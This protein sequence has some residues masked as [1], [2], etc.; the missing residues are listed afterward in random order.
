MLT[1]RRNS[2]NIQRQPPDLKHATSNGRLTSNFFATAGGVA[3]GSHHRGGF[4]KDCLSPNGGQPTASSNECSPVLGHKNG[5]A[6]AIHGGGLRPQTL[7]QPAKVSQSC[8]TIHAPPPGFDVED[9]DCL[10]PSSLQNYTPDD[11]CIESP[12]SSEQQQWP[13]RTVAGSDLHHH[14]HH[15]HDDVPPGPAP[16]RPSS[17][18][19]T[20]WMRCINP[21]HFHHHHHHHDPP[22]LPITLTHNP[23]EDTTTAALLFHPPQYQCVICQHNASLYRALSNPSLFTRPHQDSLHKATSLSAASAAKKRDSCEDNLHH[24]DHD[25]SGEC[26]EEDDDDDQDH[27]DD[28]LEE[29]EEEEEEEDCDGELTP[30][31]QL[32]LRRHRM[33][34]S[35]GSFKDISMAVHLAPHLRDISGLREPLYSGDTLKSSSNSSGVGIVNTASVHWNNSTLEREVRCS[36]ITED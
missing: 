23:I 5:K 25:E 24:D 8:Q 16:P 4:I 27:P 1:S 35:V 10:S 13:P 28:E 20:S 18:T 3:T 12:P 7:Q 36:S 34:S 9:D 32:E 21:N 26:T 15:M 22:T 31:P 19:S 2:G 33:S 29:E 30:P 14:V 11:Q 6:C 17:R